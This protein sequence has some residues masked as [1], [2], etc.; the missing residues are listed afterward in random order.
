MQTPW[1]LALDVEQVDPWVQVTSLQHATV[2]EALVKVTA[3]LQYQIENTGLKAFRVSLPVDADNVKFSGD[4]VADFLALPGEPNAPLKTWEVK[5]H[6]RVIGQYLLQVTYQ[7]P[8]AAN[9]VETGL[10]GVQVADVN[11]Q[12]GFVTVES[13]GRLQV[14]V[15]AAP[16][17]LQPTE[18]QSISRTLQKDLTASSA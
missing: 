13:S 17:A 16:A 15:D 4:Q 11:L 10:R 6:R 2:G 14:R 7:T 5:L 3:N 12:R 18:W 1:N 8:V 9:A